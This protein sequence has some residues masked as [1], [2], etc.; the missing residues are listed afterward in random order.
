MASLDK[1]FELISLLRENASIQVFEI[2]LRLFVSRTAAQYRLNK[3][4]FSDV[5]KGYSVLL[6]KSNKQKNIK[7][8]GRIMIKSQ[9][10]MTY[11]LKY[12]RSLSMNWI[13]LLI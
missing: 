12:K 11:Q 6:F 7:N 9:I 10:H 5:I 1:G 13:T 8:C 3:L 2:A 4:K